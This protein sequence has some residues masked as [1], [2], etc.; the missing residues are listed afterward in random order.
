MYSSAAYDG[1]ALIYY[2]IEDTLGETKF[3][4]FIRAMIDRYAYGTISTEEWIALAN[5]IA[6]EDLRGLI[7]S[8]L[9]YKTPPDY[10]G[11]VTLREIIEDYQ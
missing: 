1:G 9:T 7:E 4:E 8:W 5:E 2:L 6:G 10:P 11:V 3:H